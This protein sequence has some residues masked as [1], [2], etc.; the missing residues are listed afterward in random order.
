M[1]TSAHEY[2][3]SAGA[4]G[5]RLSR[6]RKVPRSSPGTTEDLPSICGSTGRLKEYSILHVESEAR[7]CILETQDINEPRPKSKLQR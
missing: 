7:F 4:V 3:S 2:F 6:V 1:C 5:Q